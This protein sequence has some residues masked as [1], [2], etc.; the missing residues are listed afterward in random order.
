LSDKDVAKMRQKIIRRLEREL[1]AAL[2]R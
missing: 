1:G 2:R